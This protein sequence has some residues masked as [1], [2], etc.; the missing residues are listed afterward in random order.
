MK[1]HELAGICGVA[2]PIISLSFVIKAIII[3]PWFAWST[4]AL[5]DLG[6]GE[7][8]LVFNSGLIAGGITSIIFALGLFVAFEKQNLR[9]TGAVVYFFV[10]ISLINIGVFSEAVGNVHL[11]FS[12]A[13]FVL[14]PI[15][16]FLLGVGAI[17][18]RFRLF[19]AFTLSIGFLAAFPW[20]FSWGAVGVPE[21]VSAVVA[22]V[23][24]IVQGARLYLA[25]A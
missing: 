18:S 25:C 20:F 3:S 21:M 24:S 6:V 4:N 19:G 23:W 11:Y 5:S 16:L 10:A 7:A 17:I 15:S 14:L 13:F 1:K 8:A 12:I 9:K 2:G 22:A